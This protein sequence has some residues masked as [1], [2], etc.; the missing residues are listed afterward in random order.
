MAAP[1]RLRAEPGRRRQRRRLAAELGVSGDDAAVD[2]E[3]RPLEHRSA[4]KHGER[5]DRSI[6]FWKSLPVSDAQTV[7]SKLLVASGVKW[8]KLEAK[9]AERFERRR[10]TRK[11]KRATATLVWGSRSNS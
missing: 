6:L 1:G 9:G 2:R 11:T 10:A 3:A 5:R 7:L 8:R 4:E